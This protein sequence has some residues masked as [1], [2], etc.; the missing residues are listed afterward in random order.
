MAVKYDLDIAIARISRHR[1]LDVTRL[2]ASQI[3]TAIFIS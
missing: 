1:G 2:R 3:F